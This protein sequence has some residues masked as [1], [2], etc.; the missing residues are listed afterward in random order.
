MISP[1]P[2][3]GATK[4]DPVP[5]DFKYNLAR[6]F[7]YR[8]QRC[9]RCRAARFIRNHPG[10]S[11]GATLIVDET[12]SSGW[13][14]EEGES[15]ETAE[16]RLEPG[17]DRVTGADSSES[18]VSH[19]PDCG[20]TSYHRTRRTTA[21][22]M[23]RR[24]PMARCESCGMR[25]PYPRH[26]EE[27]PEELNLAVAA[28]GEPDS[29]AE[30]N[31]P[32]T[33]LENTQ[34]EVRKQV[35]GTDSSD[36]NMP[37]CPACGSTKHHRT[38]RT[39]VE[40]VL[41]RRPM[42]RCERCGTRFPYSTDHAKSS[43][44]LKSGEVVTSQSH[45]GEEGVGSS[46]GKEIGGPEVVKPGRAAHSSDRESSC[47]PFCGS[48]VYRRSRRKTLERL[49]LRPKMARCSHCRKRFPFPER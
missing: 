45:K 43:D 13:L 26:R 24:P 9:S 27:Y 42:A 5:H 30:E 35:A 48:T 19:C 14:V 10:K 34:A 44:P 49:L 40:R 21:E 17:K 22:R 41:E 18:D 38:Q 8:L 2:K 16:P 20:S 46:T 32:R 31:T 29:A 4:T 33:A 11:L 39:T 6:V 28:A 47:C 25:F 7:G 37:R 15:P 36:S 12:G 23:L 3:C 1:C